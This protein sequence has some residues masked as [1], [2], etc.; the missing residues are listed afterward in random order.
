M[1]KHTLSKKQSDNTKLLI[2]LRKDFV[3]EATE[4]GRYITAY[5]DSEN[6]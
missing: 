5:Y 3:D 2:S 6:D 1:R 4:L